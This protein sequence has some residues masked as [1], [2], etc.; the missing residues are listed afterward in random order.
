MT[1]HHDAAAVDAYLAALPDDRRD[2]IAA[3]R[4]VV[5]ANL[6]AGYEESVSWGM[7]GYE[8]PLARYP[9]TYNG[10]PL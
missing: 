5:V 9:K 8:I 2:V 1:S 7:I 3:V 10:H 6:P 4:N